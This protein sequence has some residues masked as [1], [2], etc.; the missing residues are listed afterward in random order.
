LRRVSKKEFGVKN[1]EVVKENE[2]V[3]CTWLYYFYYTSVVSL[4]CTFRTLLSIV[5]FA[6]LIAIT[7]YFY[8]IAIEKLFIPPCRGRVACNKYV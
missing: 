5:E 6:L 1:E 4:S 2:E 8:A 7:L 3:L